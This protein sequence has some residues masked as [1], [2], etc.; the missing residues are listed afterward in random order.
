MSSKTKKFLAAAAL[1]GLLPAASAVASPL[2]DVRLLG[3][4]ITR[5]DS[6]FSSTVSAAPGDQIQIEVLTQLAPITTSNTNGSRTI[7]SETA[8]TD[9]VSS[10]KFNVYDPNGA[11]AAAGDDLV[12]NLN[13][14][15]PFSLQNGWNVGTGNSGG[16]AAQ[17]GNG[18]NSLNNVRPAQGAGIVVGINGSESLIGSTNFNVTSIGANGGVIDLSLNTPVAVGALTQGFKINGGSSVT[19]GSGGDSTGADPLI[20]T[21]FTTP[22]AALTIVPVPEPASLGLL[23]VAGLGLVRRRRQ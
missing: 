13:T 4:N 3:K 14:A 2:V 10:L 23:A 15:S 6:G 9:G 21:S 16:T 17:N 12:T 7:T 19:S 22:G 11:D 20:Q 8:G 18:T 5:G 1:M